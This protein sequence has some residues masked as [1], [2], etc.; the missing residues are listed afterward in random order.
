MTR[1]IFNVV[2]CTLWF[3]F[4]TQWYFFG[5]VLNF[6]QNSWNE[7]KFPF[8]FLCTYFSSLRKKVFWKN[9]PGDHMFQVE[10][11]N[12]APII[13]IF[14]FSFLRKAKYYEEKYKWPKRKKKRKLRKRMKFTQQWSILRWKIQPCI[15]HNPAAARRGWFAALNTQ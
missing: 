2:F 13:G 4:L 9:N 12:F 15:S 10:N 8:F 14:F 11:F 3:F 5:T 1:C 6:A 7:E